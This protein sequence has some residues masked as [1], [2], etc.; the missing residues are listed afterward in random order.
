MTPHEEAGD[1][2]KK[3]VMIGLPIVAVIVLLVIAG[4]RGPRQSV[5][6][7]AHLHED[8]TAA[9][10]DH[11][12]ESELT[13]RDDVHEDGDVHDVDENADAHAGDDH[14]E[15]AHDGEAD[16]DDGHADDGHADEAVDEEGHAD[17]DEGGGIVLSERNREDAGIRLAVAGPGDLQLTTR[18]LGEVRINEE[19]LAHVV[20]PVSGVVREVHVRIGDEVSAGQLLAVLA[21]R[22]LAEARAQYMNAR[23]R[24]ELALIG[25]ERQE[26]LWARQI[27]AEQDFLDARQ[28]LSEADVE[29]QTAEQTL[30]AL[31][32]DDEELDGLTM[33]HEA[34]AL[35]R[36]E[37][38]SPIAGTVIEM[39]MVMGEVLGED[40]DVLAVADLR[41]AW[42]D[43]DV[44]QTDVG[45]VYEGQKVTISASGSGLPD[46]AGVVSF[47]S[48]VI[49]E[50]TRTV[51]ARIQIP[52]ESGQWRP[53]LFVRADVSTDRLEVPVL[54]PKDA[55][56]T[57]EGESVLFVLDGDAFEI[58]DVICGRSTKTHVEIVSGLS[59]GQEYVV[60]GAYALKAEIV[61]SGLDSHAGHGH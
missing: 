36:L 7:E 12:H 23:G 47:V 34:G 16:D 48:P 6:H 14:A 58:V 26:E 33:T 45:A 2:M 52:N 17:S 27:M 22:E 60:E 57:I 35:T 42:V 54:V 8:E 31:G 13:A 40:S 44:P 55:V 43:L 61:T 9:P 39:H 18:L 32:V 25:F 51:L 19:R 4:A 50:E 20:P 24:R 38:R 49:D 11:D 15:G 1:S 3:V 28:A 41:T 29:L 46:V 53:G 5:E 37:L 30:H 21:S 59:A 10:S 56:Q